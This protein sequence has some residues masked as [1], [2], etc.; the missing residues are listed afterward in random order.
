M[1]SYIVE[2]YSNHKEK[3]RK[4]KELKNELTKKCGRNK[5]RINILDNCIMCKFEDNNHLF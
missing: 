2:P 1:C 4:I 3:I 5:Y